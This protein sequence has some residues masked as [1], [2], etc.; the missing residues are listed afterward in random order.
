MAF[1]LDMPSEQLSSD[2]INI[3]VLC[4]YLTREEDGYTVW[5]RVASVPDLNIADP[6]ELTG[7]VGEVIARMIEEYKRNPNP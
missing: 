3:V 5:H 7:K 4:Y 6:T 2:M 1:E